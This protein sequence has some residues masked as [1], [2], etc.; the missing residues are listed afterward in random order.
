MSKLS[1]E[2]RDGL[3]GNEALFS[4]DAVM[5]NLFQHP[6]TN[7]VAGGGLDPETSSG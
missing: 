4:Y 6:S 5:L 2:E 7:R 1:A 3:S